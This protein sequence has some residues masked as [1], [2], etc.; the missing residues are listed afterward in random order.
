MPG[1]LSSGVVT[2]PN[3]LGG[4]VLTF[5]G[6][7]F[8]TDASEI[9]IQLYSITGASFDIP[10][11]VITSGN[12]VIDDTH[13]ACLTPPGT[14]TNLRVRVTVAGLSTTSS[15]DRFSYALSPNID[16]VTGCTDVVG[17]GLTDTCPTEGGIV[18]TLHGTSFALNYDAQLAPYPEILV[19][20]SRCNLYPDRNL[21]PPDLFFLSLA[22]FA[23]PFC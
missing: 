19:G 13:L 17:K 1:A 20:P 12:P 2:A 7:H 6:E 18:I 3:N 11:E 9:T 23:R 16:K 14:G 5:E 10:C 4:D 8:G 15:S 21:V 22:P